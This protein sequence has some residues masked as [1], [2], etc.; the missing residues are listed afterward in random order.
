MDRFRTGLVSKWLGYDEFEKFVYGVNYSHEKL[1]IFQ[2][3]IFGGN[4]NLVYCYSTPKKYVM[5]AV[6]AAKKCIG[7]LMSDLSDTVVAGFFRFLIEN[8]T[9]EYYKLEG[10]SVRVRNGYFP[11]KLLYISAQR[12][13]GG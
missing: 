7:F 11:E 9:F 2:Q 1:C 8:K 4:P 13:I 10:P 3:S 12:L 5:D 6:L